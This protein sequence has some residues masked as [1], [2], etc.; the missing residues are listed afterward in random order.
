MNICL[1]NLCNRRC[2]YCFQRTWFLSNKAYR[3]QSVV[4]MPLQTAKEIV[5]W[6]Y[7]S[8]HKKPIQLMG[9]EPLL[10]SRIVDLL[11]YVK[12]IGEKVTIISNISCDSTIIEKIVDQFSDV[13][14][15]WLINCDYPDKDQQLFL[16]N[17]QTIANVQAWTVSLSSTII[18]GNCNYQR[19]LNSIKVVK[20]CNHNNSTIRISPYC[21]QG[22]EDKAFEM[23]NY[24][25][26]LVNLFNVL[27]NT[28]DWPV[29]LD[30]PLEKQELSDQAAKAF[31]NGGIRISTKSC[32][33]NG[34]PTDILPDGSIIWC[35]SC[36][37]IRLQSFRD[38]KTVK[39]AKNAL[40]QK[41]KQILKQKNINMQNHRCIAKTILAQSKII[42]IHEYA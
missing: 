24:T 22:S 27:Y 23:Y 4:E 16:T 6:Y 42:P 36:E 37:N 41:A 3:D 26:Q 19:L 33:T 34:G 32:V 29:G 12:T 40:K 5:D 20:G 11:Q 8:K 2:E 30:C 35:S 17:L 13:V 31:K 28:C 7:N 9:G 1:T 38:Y 39:Q 15:S 25:E 14:E 10:Y 18:A 21:P